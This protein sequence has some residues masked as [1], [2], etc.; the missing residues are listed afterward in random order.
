[1]LPKKAKKLAPKCVNEISKEMDKRL[2]I[3][4]FYHVWIN[5]F[6]FIVQDNAAVWFAHLYLDV[7][8]SSILSICLC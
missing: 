6:L 5:L 2:Q 4:L 1:M 3:Y 8:E 7:T